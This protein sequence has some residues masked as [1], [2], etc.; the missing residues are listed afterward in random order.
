VD[1]GLSVG[2]LADAFGVTYN[3]C[4]QH[5]SLLRGA[6]LVVVERNVRRGSMGQPSHALSLSPLGR[7]LVSP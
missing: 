4:Y 1:P 2:Q 7:A 3:K 6:G 5:A